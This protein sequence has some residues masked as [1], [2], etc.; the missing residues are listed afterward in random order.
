MLPLRVHMI[1]A[2]GH[3][4]WLFRDLAYAGVSRQGTTAFRALNLQ[5]R[6]RRVSICLVY[7]SGW[8]SSSKH[9][10]QLRSTYTS[11]CL[12]I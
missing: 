3:G 6:N 1:N 5:F 7:V 12:K 10:R 2:H 9:D 4:L 8:R 11:G